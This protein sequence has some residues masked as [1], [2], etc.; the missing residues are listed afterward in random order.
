[1]QE[2]KSRFSRFIELITSERFFYYYIITVMI[3]L[4]VFE[5]FDETHSNPFV[6][7]PIIVE[8]AGYV[9]VFA[10]LSHFLK[11]KDI[12]YYLSDLLYFFLFIFAVLSAVFTQNKYDT[13]HGFY[14]DEWLFNFF[15]YFSLMLAG[16]MIT[17]KQM[18]KNILK[19]FVFVTC[20]QGAVAALQ[21]AGIYIIECYYVTE[22]TMRYKISYGLTQSSN[23]YAGL[24][25]LLFACTSGIYLF[26]NKKVTRNIMYCICIFCFYTL[27]STEARLAWVGVFAYL[28]FLI[29]SFIV[30]KRKK[31]DKEK[32]SSI[33]KRTLVLAAGMIFVVAFAIVVCGKITRRIDRTM[34]EL[35]DADSGEIGSFR[36][37]IWRFGIKAIPKYWA[38]GIGLDNFADVFLKNPEYHD[39][40]L[41]QAKA[42]NEYLHYLVTQGVFQFITYISLLV[43]TIVT[44]I[45]NVINNKDEEERFIN[46]ILLGMIVGYAAQAFFNSSI[47]YIAPYFWITIG[48]CLSHKNQRYFGFSKEKKAAKQS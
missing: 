7:Q 48:M 5:V 21:T 23:W 40:D 13:W 6:T 33:I 10:F 37:Y 42:H 45:R 2:L 26:T 31:W 30:M 29:V 43:Y 11:H 44:G 34:Y 41:M 25:V 17:D 8:I 28:V 15:G 4:P 39:G 22:E 16:T 24:S 47:V 3:S 36:M 9:G 46:W 19:A 27:I 20:I 35:K 38:F 32:M 1:M 18:R 14:Y 12:K